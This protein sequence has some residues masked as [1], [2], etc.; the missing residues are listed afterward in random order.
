MNSRT[1][2]IFRILS[3]SRT[4][5]DGKA[6]PDSGAKRSRQEEIADILSFPAVS[7]RSSGNAVGAALRGGPQKASP[8]G[9]TGIPTAP[10]AK[11]LSQGGGG[12]SGGGSGRAG[13]A[14]D[15]SAFS[16]MSGSFAKPESRNSQ[17]GSPVAENDFSS[18]RGSFAKSEG[19]TEL[20]RLKPVLEEA[21]RLQAERDR[22]ISGAMRDPAKSYSAQ[23]RLDHLLEKNGYGSIEEL[24][25][26]VADYSLAATGKMS[27]GQ[28]LNRTVFSDDWWKKVLSGGAEQWAGS[29]LNAAGTTAGNIESIG[30]ES[31]GM[32]YENELRA[33]NDWATTLEEAKTGVI[34][35]DAEGIKEIENII[36]Y[37]D[38][39]LL[40]SLRS[41]VQAYETLAE[42]SAAAADEITA[43]GMQNTEKAK[44]GLG[45]GGKLA[46]DLLTQG[47]M[48]ALDKATGA[49]SISLFT[50]GFGSGAQEARQA[51]ASAQEQIAYGAA[52]GTVEA[53]TEK[54]FDG[55]AGIYGKG[56]ADKLVEDSIARMAKSRE[57]LIKSRCSD[58]RQKFSLARKKSAGILCVFQAF[59]TK[60]CGNLC[61][62]DG[63]GDLFRGSLGLDRQHC[64]CWPA[65][66]TREARKSCPMQSTR[67]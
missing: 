41:G 17:G 66:S 61:R 8:Y 52:V 32:V 24:D 21:K 55:L 20:D 37:Y 4:P 18:T 40:P 34:Q 44:E 42:D 23:T 36:A 60:T 31:A 46:V 28:T 26:A 51:G 67:C 43:K 11:P 64:V 14:A 6:K 22:Y 38:D 25:N 29:Q 12:F 15:D 7:H 2:E 27:L 35:M 56:A 57:A 50:R 1:D 5:Q 30:K 58:L 3:G 65:A 47:T 63:R 33:R 62:E 16:G 10:E 53:L 54:L 49:S 9:E 59:L 45:W 13:R 19:Q 48:M 39:Q